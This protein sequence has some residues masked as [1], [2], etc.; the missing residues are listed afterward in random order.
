VF[1]SAYTVW[2]KLYSGI[3]VFWNI[4]LDY[5]YLGLTLGLTNWS[6]AGL[7]LGL[8]T[9]DKLGKFLALAK[10]FHSQIPIFINSFTR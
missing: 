2:I 4:Q 10:K 1:C 8:H 7:T 6:T 5:L 3:Y 9:L